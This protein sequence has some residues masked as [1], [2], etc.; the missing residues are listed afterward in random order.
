MT[1]HD[2]SSS[3]SSGAAPPSPRP[4]RR[5]D[6]VV[7]IPLARLFV[8]DPD[9]TEGHPDARA[10]LD[11]Y[12]VTP[13]RTVSLAVTTDSESGLAML[14]AVW[15]SLRT[16]GIARRRFQ[17]RDDRGRTVYVMTFAP[18]VSAPTLRL[19][20]ESLVLPVRTSGGVAEVHLL[21]T[22]D[23][24]AAIDRK[25]FRDGSGPVPP[26]TVAVPP[27]RDTEGLRPEDWAFLGLLSA[28]GAFEVPD[29]P[30][31]HLLAE[32][33]GLAPDAFADRARE[34]ERGMQILVTDLFAP[35]GGGAG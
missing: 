27:A 13:D 21:A 8:P 4:S 1:A 23:E 15:R 5:R 20:R 9:P 31:P 28:V 29:G 16:K 17:L 2:P 35:A 26:S 22:P 3:P 30:T 32:L 10:D 34:I 19:A 25:L 18:D 33:F 11:G 12:V 7:S 6:H 24:A 14:D